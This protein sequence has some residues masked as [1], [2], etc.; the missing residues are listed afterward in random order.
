MK[1][2]IETA[3]NGWILIDEY[4]NDSGEMIEEKLVF[5]YDDECSEDEARKNKILSFM[6]LLYAINEKM[7]ISY[8]KHKPFNLNIELEKKDSFS[9]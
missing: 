4:E 9:I 5:S 2:N 1:I 3:S 8:S 7:G 6:E